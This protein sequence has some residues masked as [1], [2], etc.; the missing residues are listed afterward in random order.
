MGGWGVSR[1]RRVRCGAPTPLRITLRLRD[2]RRSRRRTKISL[3]IR[4]RTSV[5]F[6]LSKPHCVVRTHID[7][8]GM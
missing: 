2:A 4:D 3:R 8:P 6:V 5:D 7:R 1:A